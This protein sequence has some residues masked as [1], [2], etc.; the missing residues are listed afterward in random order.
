M[1]TLIIIEG[2][3]ISIFPNEHNPPHLHVDF[4]EYSCLIE[5]STLNVIK[6][7]IPLKMYKKIQMWIATNQTKL[8]EMFN[9][10]NSNLR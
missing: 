2:V 9:E 3:K 4:A 5:I 7:E 1:P 8:L 10:L 6:G